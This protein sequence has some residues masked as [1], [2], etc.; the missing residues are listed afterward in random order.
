MQSLNTI[1][2]QRLWRR[3]G[4]QIATAVALLCLLLAVVSI[5]W[6]VVDHQRVVRANYAAQNIAAPAR[7]NSVNY[8]VNDILS[9]NL[10]GNPAPVQVVRQAPTTT[11]NLKLQGILSAS[12]SAM[13]RAIIQ[14]GNKASELY[15]VGETIK[16]AGASVKEIRASE[17]I[18]NRNG[19]I[20]SLPLIKKSESGNR[21]IISFTNGPVPSARG[22]TAEQALAARK[23]RALQARQNRPVTARAKRSPNGAPRQIKRPNFSGIDRALKKMGEL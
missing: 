16:G 23:A 8:R 5:I 20:E 15:S 6:Q 11:L 14:T 7:S 4:V 19:A 2:N 18:L 13:A 3:N 21:P 9:A 10:F 12:D 22:G 1:I 17:V